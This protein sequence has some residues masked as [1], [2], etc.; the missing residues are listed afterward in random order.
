[1]QLPVPINFIQP[2]LQGLQKLYLCEAEC[3]AHQD[4]SSY[5]GLPLAF[6]NMQDGRGTQ[7]QRQLKVISDHI[8]L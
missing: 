7:V 1:M 4:R 2:I 8:P 5:H 6:V 3:E